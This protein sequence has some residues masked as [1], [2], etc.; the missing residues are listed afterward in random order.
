MNKAKWN[1]KQ[2]A[3]IATV[4][5]GGSP[6]YDR[7]AIRHRGGHVV[8]VAYYH[9]DDAGHLTPVASSNDV[10][11]PELITELAKRLPG[12]VHYV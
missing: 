3:E 4:D 12:G 1:A 9:R 7:F 8:D 10:Y 5:V 2:I 6:S 11:A